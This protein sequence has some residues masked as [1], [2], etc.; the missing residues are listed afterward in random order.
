[1]KWG[2]LYKRCVLLSAPSGWG[3]GWPRI[4]RLLKIF[5]DAVVNEHLF[6]WAIYKQKEIANVRAD[7]F[8]GG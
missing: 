6:Q 7:D 4:H 3:L 1:M 5:W 8:D 2:N